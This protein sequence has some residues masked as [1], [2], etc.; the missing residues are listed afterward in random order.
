[1]SALIS[2]VLMVLVVIMAVDHILQQMFPDEDTEAFR[3]AV[4]AAR[5]KGMLK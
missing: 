3:A 4:V 5:D 2:C 1:M